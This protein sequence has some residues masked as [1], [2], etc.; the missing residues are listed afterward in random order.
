MPSSSVIFLSGSMTKIYPI[1]DLTALKGF[2]LQSLVL[3]TRFLSSHVQFCLFTI[4][5]PLH[6]FVI[7]IYQLPCN[8][9]FGRYFQASLLQTLQIAFHV[10]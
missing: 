6:A 10:L 7:F 9:F 3:L 2:S 1:T 8:L 4:P 5:A